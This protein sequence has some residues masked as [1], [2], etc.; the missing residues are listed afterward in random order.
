MSYPQ[1][2]VN[3]ATY[4]F[5]DWLNT[6]NEMAYAFSTVAVTAN[7]SASPGVTTGNVAITGFVQAGSLIAENGIQGGNSTS[8]G[9]L[10]ITSN[11][12]QG[13]V[14]NGV[15]T[16]VLANNSPSQVI[17]TVPTTDFRTA[18]YLVQITAN[19]Q[20]QSTEILVLQDGNTAYSTEY[21]TLVSGSTL[22]TFSATVF[23]NTV[24]LQFNPVYAN[25][26]ISYQRTSINP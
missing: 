12:V 5:Y 22:G 10:L 18:K 11:V 7:N 8:V 14:F 19:G 16:I 1:A 25:S 21:A 23:A 2:N 26:I 15:S 24:S 3:P 4:T 6:T 13:N 17:E 20:Y 9:N